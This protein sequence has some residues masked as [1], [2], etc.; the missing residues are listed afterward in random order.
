[1]LDLLDNDASF[2]LFE[3]IEE[4]GVKIQ[5]SLLPGLYSRNGNTIYIDNNKIKLPLDQFQY[6]TTKSGWVWRHGLIEFL[7][8]PNN[9]EEDDI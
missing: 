3:I 4:L 5:L 6:D 9:E 1:M 2:S 8:I 7:L